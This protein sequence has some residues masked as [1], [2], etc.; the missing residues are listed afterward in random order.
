MALAFDL[1][2]F[3]AG[4]SIAA[5]IEIIAITINNSIRVKFLFCIETSIVPDLFL[6]LYFD[7]FFMLSSG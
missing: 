6:S 5:R 2:A 1:A 7:C 3:S 4:N